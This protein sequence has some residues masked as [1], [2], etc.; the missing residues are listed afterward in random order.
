MDIRD[1]W[2]HSDRSSA[3]HSVSVWEQEIFDGEEQPTIVLDHEWYSSLTEDECSAIDELTGDIVGSDAFITISVILHN[4][5]FRDVRSRYA[6]ELHMLQGA[7]GRLLNQDNAGVRQRGPRDR[8]SVEQHRDRTESESDTPRTDP[9]SEGDPVIQCNHLSGSFSGLRECVYQLGHEGDHSFPAQAVE[10]RFCGRSEIHGQHVFTYQLDPSS[11]ERDAY[12]LGWPHPG[13]LAELPTTGQ[14]GDGTG[15]VHPVHYNRH[16]SGVECIAIVQHHNFNVGSAIKYLWRQG[17][18]D[19]EP[20]IKDLRKA[21]EYIAFEIARLE[22]TE[23]GRL[24]E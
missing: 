8:L 10:P 20:S 1:F 3:T 15:V 4:T 11:Q 5:P 9:S 19:G 14:R 13:E 17:L 23:H 16:P 22:G 2:S 12:C 7:A 18:K 6:P 21:A 24:S